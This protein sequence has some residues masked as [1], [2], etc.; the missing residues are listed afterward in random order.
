MLHK[1]STSVCFGLNGVFVTGEFQD[2][3]HGRILSARFCSV[4]L[5]S[6]AT[7]E[8]TKKSVHTQHSKSVSISNQYG[9]LGRCLA[10]NRVMGSF[11]EHAL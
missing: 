11:G 10:G 4:A 7:L 1:A 3:Q 9:V 2:A 6:V 8:P 5:A